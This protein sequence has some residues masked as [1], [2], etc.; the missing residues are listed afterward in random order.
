[1][2]QPP[3]R[4]LYPPGKRDEYMIEIEKYFGKEYIENLEKNEGWK[5]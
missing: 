3:N 5:E 1:M 2:S 4:R